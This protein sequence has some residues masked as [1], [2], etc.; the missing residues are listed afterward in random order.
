MWSKFAVVVISIATAVGGGYING[1]AEVVC[2]FGLVWAQG[3]WTYVLALTVGKDYEKRVSRWNHYPPKIGGN[4]HY[5]AR[6][7]G[8]DF[9]DL[10]CSI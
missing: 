2:D 3:Q 7:Q 1:T 4:S 5:K 6:Q 9:W 8:F 10:V